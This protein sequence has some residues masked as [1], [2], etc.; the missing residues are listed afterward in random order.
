MGKRMKKRLST[1]EVIHRWAHQTQSE[2]Y[3]QDVFYEERAI[4][5]YGRHYLLGLLV[6]SP[7]GETVALI[8]NERYSATTAKH[9]AWAHQAVSHMP[10]MRVNSFDDISGE[11]LRYQG[12]VIDMLFDFFNKRRT[13]MDAWDN[14]YSYKIDVE[15][16]NHIAKAFKRDDLLLHVSPEFITLFN[17]H[18]LALRKRREQERSPEFL[19]RQQADALKRQAKAIANWRLGGPLPKAVR[20]LP[21]QLIRVRGDVVETSHGASVPVAHAIRLLRMV[22]RGTAK[23][24]EPIGNY[25]V[26]AV[27]SDHIQIGCHKISLDEAR[28]V[29]GGLAPALTLAAEQDEVG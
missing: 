7:S 22:E 1:D 27:H 19:E 24:N 6:D 2:A 17:D 14:D 20:Y 12:E 29:L 23:A 18:C 26:S 10:N 11:L 15:G 21:N 16:F 28:Q 8:N 3:S 4:Y 25:R 13:Y 5:S 9:Q